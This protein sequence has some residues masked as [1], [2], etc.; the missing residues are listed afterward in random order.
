MPGRNRGVRWWRE[1]LIGRNVRWVRNDGR[2]WKLG[3]RASGSARRAEPQ[4]GGPAEADAIPATELGRSR[5]AASGPEL[6]FENEMEFV[7]LPAALARARVRATA[8]QLSYQP[9]AV[10]L[11]LSLPSPPAAIRDGGPERRCSRWAIRVEGA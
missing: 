6:E 7:D 8:N 1:G 2:P 9:S 4:S 5:P 10:C 3:R 11:L